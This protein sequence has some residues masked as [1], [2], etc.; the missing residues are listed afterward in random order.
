MLAATEIVDDELEME[1][2]K[3]DEVK[4]A[5]DGTPQPSPGFRYVI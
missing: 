4:P 3:D 1:S 5:S 2:L